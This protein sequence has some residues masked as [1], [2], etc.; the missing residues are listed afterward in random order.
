[1]PFGAS[2][3]PWRG[4]N[5]PPHGETA[6][7]GR[8]GNT[9]GATAP[10]ATTSRSQDQ[11]SAAAQ[12]DKIVEFVPGQTAV[13]QRHIISG[14]NGPMPLGHHAILRIEAKGGARVST[15]KFKFDK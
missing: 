9:S 11:G 8:H 6:T 13:Y 12:V 3:A 10:I 5:H 14:M 2:D 15:S 7:N 4:E 1:M